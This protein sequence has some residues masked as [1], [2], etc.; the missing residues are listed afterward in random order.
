MEKREF[1]EKEI[2]EMLENEE[3]KS[4]SFNRAFNVCLGFSEF[5]KILYTRTKN[6]LKNFLK[7]S[8]FII[9]IDICNDGRGVIA[10]QNNERL[11]FGDRQIIG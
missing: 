4:P 7:N 10:N 5:K 3:C 8:K 11:Y 6:E 9:W 1:N 2:I